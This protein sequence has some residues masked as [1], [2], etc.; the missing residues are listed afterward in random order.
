MIQ[1]NSIAKYIGDLTL[2]EEVSFT[3]N[4]GEK[5]ALVGP[6]GAGKTTLLNLITLGDTPDMGTITI[7]EGTTVAYLRQESELPENERV[8]DAIFGADNTLLI[9]V[10]EYENALLRND[11]RAIEK[12]S[13]EMDRLKLWDYESRIKQMLSQLEIT[14][15]NQKIQELSGGQKKRVTLANALLSEPDLLILDEPTNHLDLKAI[16]WLENYIQRASL[17]LLM[18]THDRYFLDRICNVIFEIDQ[19]KVF[20]YEG[21]YSRFIVQ[22]QKRLESEQMEIMKARNQLRKE[23]DWMQRMP[24]ARGT[25]AKYRISNYHRLREIS[26]R[27]R[28]EAEM[29]LSLNESRLGSKILIAKN[30]GFAWNGTSYLKNFS[31]TF[32]RREKIGII[33]ENGSGKS[34]FLEIMMQNL[35]PD[36]GS[37]ET[38]E[39][40]R[41][42]YFRQE[43][44]EFD[45][46]MRILDAVTDI[47]ETVEIA[48]GKRITTSQFLNHFLFPPERQHDFIAKLS[49]GEK[50]RLYLCQ[51]LMQNPNFL[52]LDE[53]TNDFDIESLQVLEDYLGNFN[54]CLLVV[55]HDRYF[56]DSV[57]DHLFVFQGNGDIKDFPGNYSVF[58]E[59]K[60][61]QQST[62]ENQVTRKP[63]EKQENY[64]EKKKLSF[65]E[66]REMDTL[67][68]EIED[69]E[70]EKDQLESELS[71]GELSV[72]Q[73]RRKSERLRHVIEILEQKTDRWLELSEWT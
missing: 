51:V 58:S 19:E 7:L 42:G 66:K 6:N 20:R 62:K 18:V 35:M 37:I 53:P 68:K 33:G 52:V 1:L 34:T 13:D 27:R 69:L 44:M 24:K 21:N 28:K 47:A 11:V 63:S 36:K 17:T 50:R 67:E 57:V 39:T 60:K 48:K 29:K 45:T 72:E 46:N 2:F 65:R 9:P 64:S 70:N 49:G 3:L 59:W 8:I 10:K 61:T 26:K 14:N 54:G 23:T 31:Y 40:I 25:K 43:G 71:S 41:F 55:S 16:E 4:K 56:M 73:L 38:G 5:A 15:F 30:L 12:A 32:S 22:R